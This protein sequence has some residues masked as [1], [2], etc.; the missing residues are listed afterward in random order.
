MC[1]G[2]RLLKKICHFFSQSVTHGIMEGYTSLLHPCPTCTFESYFIN[3][4]I[5]NYYWKYDTHGKKNSN[6]NRVCSIKFI[7]PWPWPLALFSRGSSC[8]EFLLYLY[9]TYYT[10]ISTCVSNLLFVKHILTYLCFPTL[11]CF[12]LNKLR[13]GL[14]SGL[15]M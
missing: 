7:S 13:L 2:Q 10:Y 8:L 14:T 15:Y 12:H 11:Y 5:F 6:S 1:W 4:K 9:K 3:Q